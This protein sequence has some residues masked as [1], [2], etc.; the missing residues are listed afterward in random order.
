MS[1]A[2]EN[3]DIMPKCAACGKGDDV[4]KACT[5]CKMIKYCNATCQR[6]HWLKHKKECKNWAAELHDEALFK[7][8]PPN[9]EC[10]I[11]MLPLPLENGEQQYKS[12]CGKMICDGCVYGVMTTSEPGDLLRIMTQ[13]ATE[14]HHD[15]FNCPFCRTPQPNTDREIIIR[16]EKRV[17]V[18]D[19]EAIFELGGHCNFGSRGLP[20]TGA[21][22]W[23]SIFGQESLDPRQQI[24]TLL[25]LILTAKV[26]KET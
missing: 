22:Q 20:Q 9:D 19:P 6:E 26:S 8:P 10:P 18:N 1:A 14:R 4:L 24:S 7:K 16:L 2:V 17:E 12:C 23:N 25:P 11:C 21:R 3:N 15:C 5:A 13:L